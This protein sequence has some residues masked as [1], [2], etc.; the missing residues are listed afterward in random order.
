L[1]NYEFFNTFINSTVTT[2]S[3]SLCQT[4]CCFFGAQHNVPL[5][6]ESLSLAVYIKELD[7]K[8]KDFLSQLCI[9]WVDFKPTSKKL[10]FR[11]I[12]SQLEG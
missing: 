4:Q 3:P 8:N 2:T 10:I 12:I 6:Q 11:A 7:L 1:S 5:W 9:L